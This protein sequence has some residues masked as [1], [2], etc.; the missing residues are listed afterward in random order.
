MT[1]RDYRNFLRNYYLSSSLYDFIFAYA[2]YNVMFNLKGLSIYKISILLSWW[3]LTAVVLEIP[4]GALADYWSRKKLLV[5]APLIKALCFIIWFFAE[6]NFYMYALGFLLWS[7]GSSLKSGT[8]E[9][10][11]FDKLTSLNETHEHEK[12]LGK[13]K[14]YF[15][16]A[17]ALSIIIGGI[18]AHYNLNLVLLLSVIPLLLSSYF[19]AL[20]KEAPKVENTSEIHYLEYI[21]IAYSEV[22]DNKVLGYLIFYSFCISIFGDIEEFDQLYYKLVNLPLYLFGVVGFIWSI[23][24][25]IGSYY[26]YRFK[27]SN[28][29]YYVSPFLGAILLMFVGLFPAYPMIMLLLLSY[30]ITS[31]LSILIDTKIQHNINTVSRATVTSV[32]ELIINLFGIILM[33]V[34]GIISKLW[35]LNSIYITSA[36][37]LLIFSIWVFRNRRI[38][39]ESE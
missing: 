35:N 8:T 17:L 34:F 36:I 32:K 21:K 39:K 23:L 16:I 30:F 6:G 7:T 11:L 27:N 2:I 15:H 5:I 12:I 31:P 33:P 19:A 18:V 4:S 38:F 1:N 3:A 9:A 26:A 13:K 29:I 25:S 37:F 10:L 22:K 28:W 20:I 24:N 14:F